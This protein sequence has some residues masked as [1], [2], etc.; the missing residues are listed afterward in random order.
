MYDKSNLEYSERKNNVPFFVV[1]TKSRNFA[2]Q[3]E[4]RCFR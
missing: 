1:Q 4:Y 2:A 3:N